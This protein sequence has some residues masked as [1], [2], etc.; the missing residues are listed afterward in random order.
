VKPQRYWSLTGYP[1]A[2]V[3][4]CLHVRGCM[5]VASS[6]WLLT[7]AEAEAYMRESHDHRRCTVCAPDI[8]EPSWLR[9]RTPGGRVRW[10]LV[11]EAARL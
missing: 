3:G 10:R 1:F 5:Y 2:M 11:D 4:G 6:R 7:P 9:V 8:P